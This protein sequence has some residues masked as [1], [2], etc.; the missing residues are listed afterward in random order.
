MKIKLITPKKSGNILPTCVLYEPERIFENGSRIAAK[1]P[2][3]RDPLQGSGSPE[4]RFREAVLRFF[5]KL[6]IIKNSKNGGGE[7]ICLLFLLP[8]S[9]QKR[10]VC[11]VEGSKR[12]K[13]LNWCDESGR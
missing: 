2:S 6:G 7:A 3:N 1:M 4:N 12:G 11:I 10:Q 13:K 8:I 9:C 5:S